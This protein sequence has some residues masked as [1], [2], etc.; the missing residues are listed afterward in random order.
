MPGVL[1][2]SPW[3]TQILDLLSGEL[4]EILPRMPSVERSPERAVNR[5]VVE[6]FVTWKPA[7][8]LQMGRLRVQ[9]PQLHLSGPTGP[10]I[11]VLGVNRRSQTGCKTRQSLQ[12]I[13]GGRTLVTQTHN[14]L[15]TSPVPSWS[16]GGQK[17]HPWC[18]PAPGDWL[19]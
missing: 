18:R 3:F 1:D 4:G 8:V 14:D 6:T 12:A 13:L 10:Q 16:K 19:S 11:P 17:C 7:S 2:Q 9:E 5:A 15:L